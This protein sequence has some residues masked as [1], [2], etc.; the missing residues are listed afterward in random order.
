MTVTSRAAK[1]GWRS[2][3]VACALAAAIGAFPAGETRSQPFPLDQLSRIGGIDA[4]DFPQV[5]GARMLRA[6]FQE[7]RSFTMAD[8]S[9]QTLFIFRASSCWLKERTAAERAV[10]DCRGRIGPGVFIPVLFV[11]PASRQRT[12]RSPVPDLVLW[13]RSGNSLADFVPEELLDQRYGPAKGTWVRL[14]S[15]EADSLALSAPAAPAALVLCVPVSA[16]EC[17]NS[18][19]AALAN[20]ADTPDQAGAAQQQPPPPAVGPPPTPVIPPAPRPAPAPRTATAGPAAPS[21]PAP[22][23][24][25]GGVAQANPAPPPPVETRAPSAV[26]GPVPAAAQLHYVIRPAIGS[27]PVDWNTA[28]MAKRLVALL[29]STESKFYLKARDGVEVPSSFTP[30]LTGSGDA[31]V[32]WSGDNP[33]GSTE[34]IFRGVEGLEL[35]PWTQPAETQPTASTLASPRIRA[36]DFISFAEYRIAAPFL[37]DQWQAGIEAVTRVYGREQPYAFSDTCRFSLLIPRTGWISFL[38][39]P[40]TVGLERADQGGKNVLL[41]PPNIMPAQLMR[42]QGEPL[43]LDVQ[44]A[45]SGQGCITDRIS[46]AAFP[47]AAGNPGGPWKLSAVP[48]NPSTGRMDMRTAGLTVPGRWLLGLYG[49]QYIGAG[50]EAGSRAAADAQDQIFNALTAF[51]DNLR[52]RYFQNAQP[53]SAAIGTDLALISAADAVSPNF[54]EKNVITGKFRQPTT[55]NGLFR[56][57]PE[58]NRR[59]SAFLSNSGNTSGEVSFRSV[60]QM[61]RHYSDL[62]GNLSGPRPP[63]AI[64]VGAA[65]PGPGTCPEWK[66]MTA[67]TAKLPGRPRVFAVVFINA[68]TD[69]ITQQLGPNGRGEELLGGQTRAPTCE[70]D[71]GST[72]LFVPFADLLRSPEAVLRPAFELVE[73]WTTKVQN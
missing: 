50:T 26:P 66:H 11:T 15:P 14:G 52:E 53:A 71:S 25:A 58:G 61:I 37:Y 63:I 72:L 69:D 19:N 12:E 64:Y 13:S 31:V 6:R 30:E 40:V 10:I 60:G 38:T 44:P 27:V 33:Q 54:A 2:V 1:R 32:V 47:T 51:L 5:L 49:P 48:G 16:S 22:P 4:P 23:G 20:L 62:F 9:R 70:G 65:R 34:F 68:A 21:P 36:T 67:D 73:R 17:Q 45:N 55:P 57:D 35:L 3:A 39:G 24:S 42:T 18:S 43:L 46:L 41:S 29:A 56:L 7:K 28:R 59:L 8:G